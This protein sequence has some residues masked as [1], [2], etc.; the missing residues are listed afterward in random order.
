STQTLAKIEDLRTKYDVILFPPVGYGASPNLI[1]NGLPTAWGNPLPWKTT[2]ETPNLVGKNDSTDEMEPGLGWAG[3]VQQTDVDVE[4]GVLVTS[5][6]RY[7]LASS[8]GKTDGVIL[9]TA[10]KENIVGAVVG[11]RLVD[12]ESPIAYGYDQKVAAYCDQC[13]IFSL[14]SVAGE[15]RRRRLGSHSTESATDREMGE[16]S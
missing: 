3:G 6:D 5:G 7:R 10:Q 4:G 1:V 15:R 14:T 8:I 13:A 9:G 12:A 16:Q 11:T 2:P